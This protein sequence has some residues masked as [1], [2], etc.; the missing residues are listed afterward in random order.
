MLPVTKLFFL[1]DYC[2]PIAKTFF[3]GKTEGCL[4]HKFSQ[5]ISNT[6]KRERQ[7]CTLL[8]IKNS[9]QRFYYSWKQYDKIKGEFIHVR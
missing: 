2:F 8:S 6:F 4:F 5:R 9:S 1:K 3:I 7:H